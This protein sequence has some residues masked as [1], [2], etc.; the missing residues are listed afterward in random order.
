MTWTMSL[1]LIATPAVV[2]PESVAEVPA[3]VRV[4]AL[5]LNRKTRSMIP[6]RLTSWTELPTEVAPANM[7]LEALMLAGS[8]VEFPSTATLT[9]PLLWRLMVLVASSGLMSMTTVGVI[10]IGLDQI[11]ASV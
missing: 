10:M 3:M 8:K 2:V 1:S 5:I 11:I 7:T 9:F 6:S 4:G